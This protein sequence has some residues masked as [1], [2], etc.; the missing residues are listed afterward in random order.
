MPF[1]SRS[2]VELSNLKDLT[3]ASSYPAV[4]HLLFADDSLMFVKASVEGQMKWFRFWTL[5][6]RL[7]DR[8]LILI[9]LQSFLAKDAWRVCVVR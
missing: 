2:V 4:N 5:T 1:K 9:N 6:V 7:Q 3:V 8:G